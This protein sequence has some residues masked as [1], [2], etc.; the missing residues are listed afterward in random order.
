MNAFF[1]NLPCFYLSCY[2]QHDNL[3][4]LDQ[5]RRYHLKSTWSNVSHCLG[6]KGNGTHSLVLFSLL[7]STA[8]RN[9]GSLRPLLRRSSEQTSIGFILRVLIEADSLTVK[10]RTS[11]STPSLSQP[12]WALQCPSAS[13][14]LQL[15]VTPGSPLGSWSTLFGNLGQRDCYRTHHE[16][17]GGASVK[18]RFSSS[19]KCQ[20]NAFS[21]TKSSNWAA[22]WANKE[23]ETTSKEILENN[24][25]L[26]KHLHEER[27]EGVSS[28]STIAWSHLHHCSLRWRKRSERRSPSSH[29]LLK[30]LR[31]FSMDFYSWAR[32]T[33]LQ[34]I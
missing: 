1:L 11:H 13:L 8:S 6:E 29:G 15:Q 27:D 16:A 18:F 7:S 31:N 3:R 12:H 23:V 30:P 2:I 14:T 22:P 20:Q 26:L 21:K 19:T 28:H 33:D 25:I 34:I 17:S 10:Y 24:N 9:I 5:P 32:G 4:E